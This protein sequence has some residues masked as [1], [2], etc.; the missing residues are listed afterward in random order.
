[1][2]ASAAL[3]STRIDR[4]AADADQVQP[5]LPGTA[6][7]LVLVTS[8]RYLSIP[9][10]TLSVSLGTLSLDQAVEMFHLTVGPQREID[11]HDTVAEIVELCGRLPLAIWIAAIRVVRRPSWTVGQFAARLRDSPCRLVELAV[12]NQEVSTAFGVSYQRLKPAAHRAFHLLALHPG[13]S[14]ELDEAAALIDAT[15]DEAY[16]LLET[17]V[18]HHLLLQHSFTRYR[19]HDLL[20][21]YAAHTLM[22]PTLPPGAGIDQDGSLGRTIC[23]CRCGAPGWSTALGASAT[24]TDLAHQ[25]A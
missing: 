23:E 11:E 13:E 9:S 6:N 14:F 21:E 8:R 18:D 22:P 7:C 19:F 2:S 10:G 17:L 5:L 16:Q 12:D 20:R 24:G 25:P 3:S 1:W 15:P 4:C